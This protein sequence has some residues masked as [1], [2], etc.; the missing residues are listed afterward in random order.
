MA[1]WKMGCNW[2]GKIILGSFLAAFLHNS[3]WFHICVCCLQLSMW[4]ASLVSI[5]ALIW[6]FDMSSQS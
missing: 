5:V 2:K 1:R 4:F 3:F 6:L